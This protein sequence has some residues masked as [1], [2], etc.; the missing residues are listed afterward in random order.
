MKFG[1]LVAPA[2]TALL[3]VVSLLGHMLCL[4][5]LGSLGGGTSLKRQGNGRQEGRIRVALNHHLALTRSLGS[6]TAGQAG[7]KWL[8]GIAS[9]DIL[10]R[11]V[12][13]PLDETQDTVG[14]I[15]VI[16][17]AA[18]AR[19][20]GSLLSTLDVTADLSKI[21]ANSQRIM[22][23][24]KVINLLTAGIV[25]KRIVVSSLGTV[26]V[27]AGNVLGG[28]LHDGKGLVKGELVNAVVHTV[29]VV[30]HP[31]ESAGNLRVVSVTIAA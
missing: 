10:H 17:G 3:G 18:V 11:L 19:N 14:A 6:T 8:D 28:L 16:V 15:E 1:H 29:E 5:N 31:D 12:P 2:S 4:G 30:G 22:Q 21:G 24:P 23:K 26:A 7:N 27:G 20:N 9:P 25:S 13:G